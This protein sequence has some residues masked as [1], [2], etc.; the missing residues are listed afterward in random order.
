MPNL[1]GK[2][3]LV[4]GS[5]RGIGA[6]IAARL[7]RDGA[8]VIVNYARSAQAAERV[9]ESIRASGGKAAVARADV[10][11]AVEAFGLVQRTIRELGRLDIVVNNAALIA[12]APFDQVEIDAVSAQFATNVMGPVAIVKEFLRHLPADGGRVINISS[13]AS[14]YAL[15]GASVYSATKGALDALTRVW[16]HEL[17][18]RGVTVN[19]VSP[20]P[21]H[22]DAAAEFLTDE[23]RKTF[24]TRTPLG[25]IGEPDDIAAVVAFLASPDA[26]WITGHVVAASGGFTP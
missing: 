24:V 13:L 26:A 15:P 12:P 9:A 23:A 25:R 19:A 18:P 4:T 16:A 6:A 7:A 17:G 5:A 11:I 20:G 21:V 22:T 14:E 10:G 3:A 1:N 2:V 8:A